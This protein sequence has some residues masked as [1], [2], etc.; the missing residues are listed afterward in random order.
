MIKDI[1][2]ITKEIDEFR[3]NITGVDSIIDHLKQTKICLK[4]NKEVSDNQLKK[5]S[6]N[7]LK[8]EKIEEE[9]EHTF[10]KNLKEIKHITKE[11]NDIIADSKNEVTSL[12]SI[13]SEKNLEEI[14][15]IAKETNDIIADSKNEVTSLI[16]ISNEKNELFNS[17]ITDLSMDA[18]SLLDEKI[19]KVNLRIN[20]IIFLLLVIIVIVVFL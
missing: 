1:D 11:T 2:Q 18:K 3:E 14:R 9:I 7:I 15:R 10:E 20:L 6:E 16:S 19:N 5:M 8:L 4:G 17:N 12:I 13:S